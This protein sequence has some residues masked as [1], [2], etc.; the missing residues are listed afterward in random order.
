MRRVAAAAAQSK[1]ED[2]PTNLKSLRQ[3]AE[4]IKNPLFRFLNREFNT[5]RKTLGL[6]Q[7]HIGQMQDV[8]NG[9]LKCS[10]LLRSLFSALNNE[11]IPKQW[12]LYPIK[13]IPVTLWYK[14]LKERIDQLNEIV[15]VDFVNK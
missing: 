6:V 4:S 9:D 11:A 7:K 14:D 10:N 13:P 15:D 5:G 2:V 3:D 12:S 1:E 8:V